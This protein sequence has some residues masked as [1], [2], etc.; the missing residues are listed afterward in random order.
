MR[1][2]SDAHGLEGMFLVV[3]GTTVTARRERNSAVM[4]TLWG[5]CGFLLCKK[6][7]AD[8]QIMIDKVGSIES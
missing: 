8:E 7:R 1:D 6:R 3:G 2:G 4:M 5:Y